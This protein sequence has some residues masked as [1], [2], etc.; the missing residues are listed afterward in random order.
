MSLTETI[1]SIKR[2]PTP[3]YEPKPIRPEQL[4]L[5]DDWREKL[6]DMLPEDIL[7]WTAAH[8]SF[9]I[10][11]A[12]SCPVGDAVLYTLFERLQVEAAAFD[13]M[14]RFLLPEAWQPLKPEEEARETFDGSKASAALWE[15]FYLESLCKQ[16]EGAF[17]RF[18]VWIIGSRRDQNAC[19][20]RLPI[21]SWN[22]RFGIIRIAPLAHWTG[23]QLE[24]YFRSLI[25]TNAVTS[26]DFWR[27]K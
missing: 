16:Y 7:S 3:K 25:S 12:T 11:L 23:R 10:A 2:L 26:L 4:Q 8:F 14:E 1:D 27:P 6:E 5:I 13:R 22:E 20:R 17:S 9:E 21:V 15:R 24:D 18:K 19:L